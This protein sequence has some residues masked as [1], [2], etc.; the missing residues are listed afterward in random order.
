MSVKTTV[1]KQSTSTT[2]VGCCQ[3]SSTTPENSIVD[4]IEEDFE[5]SNNNTLSHASNENETKNGGKVAVNIIGKQKGINFTLPKRPKVDMEFQNV[6]YAVKQFSF[7]QRQFGEHF[8]AYFQFFFLFPVISIIGS[9][10]KR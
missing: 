5:V 10:L 7:K 2:I 8:A 6:K 3:S 9:Y 1:E 4:Y